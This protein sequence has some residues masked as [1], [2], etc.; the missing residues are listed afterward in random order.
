[1]SAHVIHLADRRRPRQIEKVWTF[2]LRVFS[3]PGGSEAFIMDTPADNRHK[4]E[5]LR[6][7]AA[8]LDEVRFLMLQQA[9]LLEPDRDGRIVATASIYESSRVQLRS[10]EEMVATEAAATWLRD[11][12]EDAKGA[13]EVVS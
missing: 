7:M 11:R 2:D 13:V 8:Q 10:N 9:H 12:L 4:G 6:A 5:Q 1:M 3:V